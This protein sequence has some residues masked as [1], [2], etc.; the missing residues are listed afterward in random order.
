MKT[1]KITCRDCKK[2]MTVSENTLMFL[3]CGHC[4]SAY[5]E[6]NDYVEMTC[7][8][9]HMTTGKMAVQNCPKCP[10]AARTPLRTLRPIGAKDVDFFTINNMDEL[11]AFA[12]SKEIDIGGIDWENTSPNEFK[13][14]IAK[15]LETETSKDGGNKEKEEEEEPAKK[16]SLKKRGKK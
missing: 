1:I 6:F 8:N 9:G 15:A 14:F 16:I 2:E 7:V 10:V 4:G 5:L 12:I 3:T 13:M 11:R